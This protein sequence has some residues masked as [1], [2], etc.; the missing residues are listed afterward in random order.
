VITNAMLTNMAT[1]TYK[2]RTSALTGDP[3]DVPVATLKSDLVLVKGD[4]GLGNVDNTS[5]TNKPVSTAQAAATP[6]SYQAPNLM[7]TL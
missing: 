2:G 6:W 1:K 3:E 5:D 4:V 7:P